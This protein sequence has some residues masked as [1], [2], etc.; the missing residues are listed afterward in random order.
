MKLTQRGLAVRVMWEGQ[1]LPWWTLF[2]A[3]RPAA[4]V[5]KGPPVLRFL[6]HLG[7]Q[8]LVTRTSDAMTTPEQVAR[9]PEIDLSFINLAGFRQALHDGRLAVSGPEDALGHW[10]GRGRRVRCR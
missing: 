7:N 4:S 10:P 6:S 5:P 2:S 1:R 3:G 8:L 9:R